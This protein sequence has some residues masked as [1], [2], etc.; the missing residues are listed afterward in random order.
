MQWVLPT[1]LFIILPDNTVKYQIEDQSF[2]GVLG[3]VVE[4][5]GVT[6]GAEVVVGDDPEGFVGK[7][8]KFPS[9]CCWDMTANCRK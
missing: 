9:C 8:I 5:T 4:L 7:D 1:Y 3:G 2:S 6:E